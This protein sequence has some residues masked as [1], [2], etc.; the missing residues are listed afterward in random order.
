MAS[1]SLTQRGLS[2]GLRLSAS[3]HASYGR[4]MTSSLPEHLRKALAYSAMYPDLLPEPDLTRRNYVREMLERQDMLSRR[5]AI[6][7]PE[8]YVGSYMSITVS[9]QNAPG[10]KNTFV[11]ICIYRRNHGLRHQMALRNIVENEGIE[12]LYDLYSPIILEIKVLR[13]QKRLDDDLRYLRDALPEYSTVPW[14]MEPEPHREQGSVPVDETRVIMKP[15]PWTQRWERKELKGVKEWGLEDRFFK[16]AVEV[17]KP[18]EKYD[19][20]KEYR[21]M[22]PL[23]DQ[24]VVWKE[25]EEHR[26]TIEEEHKRSR[27]RKLLDA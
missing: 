7:I 2:R 26:K 11:G 19:L 10:K 23:E 18:W 1:W 14:D 20:M 16:R 8:F 3:M 22:V 15:R 5:R 4:R 9:D 13:L 21:C 17:S 6:D 12:M 27:R 24:Y 25:V